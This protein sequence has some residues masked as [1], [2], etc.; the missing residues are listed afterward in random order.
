M[1]KHQARNP[2]KILLINPE[3]L[4]RIFTEAPSNER[5]TILFKT[6]SSECFLILANIACFKS[7]A[8][9]LSD[10]ATTSKNFIAGLSFSGSEYVTYKTCCSVMLSVSPSHKI[11][12]KL[13]KGSF[14]FSLSSNK[15]SEIPKMK[16]LQAVSFQFEL[17]DFTPWSFSG[18]A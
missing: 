7:G 17:A 8:S 2:R 3:S 14:F 10:G 18:L 1:L 13:T 5:K 9:W 4:H 11:A 6:Y 12:I 15:Y 16:F